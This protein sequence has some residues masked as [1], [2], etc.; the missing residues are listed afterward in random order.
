MFKIFQEKISNCIEIS[1]SMDSSP[2]EQ[3]DGAVDPSQEDSNVLVPLLLEQYLETKNSKESF[4]QDVLNMMG[5]ND[6]N[7]LPIANENNLKIIES[8]RV[9]TESKIQCNEELKE[10][11]QELDKVEN[12]LKSG[13]NEFDQNLKLLSAHKSQ[14]STEHHLFKLAENDCSRWKKQIKEAVKE[15]NELSQ[16]EESSK[17]KYLRSKD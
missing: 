2:M 17:R 1:S 3:T 12:L 10:R 8:I 6:G 5:W 15:K 14:Y 9:L 16:F 13:I 11:N 4:I 7:F